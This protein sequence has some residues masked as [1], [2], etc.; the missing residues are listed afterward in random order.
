MLYYALTIFVNQFIRKLIVEKGFWNCIFSVKICKNTKIRFLVIRFS[1]LFS[2]TIVQKYDGALT[3]C[4]IFVLL[5][6]S[7]SVWAQPTHDTENYY[8]VAEAFRSICVRQSV[9]IYKN[10]CVTHMWS[11]L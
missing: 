9:L 6:Y 11:G 8:V 10:I 4:I 5:L 3:G 7:D 2:G 1:P